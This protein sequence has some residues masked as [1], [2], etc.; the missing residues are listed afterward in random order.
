[1][2]RLIQK[3]EEEEEDTLISGRDCEATE[4]F[5]V[6][7]ASDHMA[8]VV[9]IHCNGQ[10]SELLIHENT[11]EMDNEIKFKRPEDLKVQFVRLKLEFRKKWTRPWSF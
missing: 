3:E 11:S 8:L 10:S 4:A 5:V 6:K 7:F 9:E 2:A 1:M